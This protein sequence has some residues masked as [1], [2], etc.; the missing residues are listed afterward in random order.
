VADA[1]L[2]DALLHDRQAA[3]WVA[4]RLAPGAAL[5]HERHQ[6]EVRAWLL[7]HDEMPAAVKHATDAAPGEMP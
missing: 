5:I 7:R 4:R 1:A 3:G 2:L 6:A